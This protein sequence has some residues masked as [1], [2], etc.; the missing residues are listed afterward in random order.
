M[1]TEVRLAEWV[2][3]VDKSKKLCVDFT[4]SDNYLYLFNV[5][6]R[7]ICSLYLFNVNVRVICSLT[8]IIHTLSVIYNFSNSIFFKKKTEKK[9][10][11]L[12]TNVDFITHQLSVYPSNQIYI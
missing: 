10:Q 5:N 7:V 12:K 4:Y 1:K 9:V 6:V 3:K 11:M 2:N 8:C